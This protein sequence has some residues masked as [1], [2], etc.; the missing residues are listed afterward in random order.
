MLQVKFGDKSELMDIDTRLTV[1]ELKKLLRNV[2][3][4]PPSGIR[5]FHR[6]EHDGEYS[7]FTEELKLN[8]AK[9]YSYNIK[10]GDVLIVSPKSEVGPDFHIKF[11]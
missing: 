5:I 9:V 1:L 6:E 2:T 4:L 7:S 3:G 11:M 8:N 10:E